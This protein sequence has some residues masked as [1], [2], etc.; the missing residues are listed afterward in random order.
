MMELLGREEANIA[1]MV[2]GWMNSQII[3]MVG[4][5][6]AVIAFGTALLLITHR[7]NQQR[8]KVLEI[9][10]G[11]N[12]IQIQGFSSKTEKF[13]LSLHVEDSGGEIDVEEEVENSR[14]VN[15][16]TFA[17]KKRF[18]EIT[19]EKGAYLRLLVLPILAFGFFLHSFLVS[20]LSL[21]L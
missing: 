10:L 17:K 9:F 14:K 19:F 11:V 7:I 15:S 2:G 6:L 12:E 20:Y 8:L 3:M 1:E 21:S 5:L 4:G 16:S 13:L 18:K